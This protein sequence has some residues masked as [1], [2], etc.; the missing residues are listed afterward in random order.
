MHVCASPLWAPPHFLQPHI[1]IL[2]GCSPV[3]SETHQRGLNTRNYLRKCDD[4]VHAGEHQSS[5]FL[6]LL[7]L[8]CRSAPKQCPPDGS[9]FNGYMRMLA[10][11]PSQQTSN[12]SSHEYANSSPTHHPIRVLTLH[13][14]NDSVCPLK[15]ITAF[16]WVVSDLSF[17][18]S[19]F[20]ICTYQDRWAFT[21][22]NCTY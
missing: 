15:S 5:L 9:D 19:F 8:T 21:T 7:F 14:L 10:S 13:Y 4:D 12:S 17:N 3:H 1:D 16:K 11:I 2:F 18:C 20:Q 22:A 6:L